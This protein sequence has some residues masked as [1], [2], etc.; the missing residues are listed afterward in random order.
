MKMLSQ[1]V[2]NIRERITNSYCSG[3]VEIGNELL[4]EN[5]GFLPRQVFLECLGN[6]D[7]YLKKYQAAVNFYEEAIVSDPDYQISRYQYLVGV[8]DEREKDLV[9]A[10]KRYQA[11]IEIEPCFVD[12]YVEL[13]GL[14]VKVGDFEGA[15]QC[16][17]DAL[18]LAPTEAENFLNLRFV[19]SELV[20]NGDDKYAIELADIVATFEKHGN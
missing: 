7:F 17:R 8:Q 3:E 18:R 11:A 16:Y 12:A 5:E 13:G 20:Q 6:R 9:A 2:K 1:S 19:L 4:A 14:L 10:F 15:V